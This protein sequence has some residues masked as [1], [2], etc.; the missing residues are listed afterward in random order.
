MRSFALNPAAETA[1]SEVP[2]NPLLEIVLPFSVFRVNC[3]SFPIKVRFSGRIIE[4]SSC[5][6][7]A[8]TRSPGGPPAGVKLLDVV[9]AIKNSHLGVHGTMSLTDLTG[10]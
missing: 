10:A 4:L 6:V 9:F 1:A 2:M 7:H 5:K 3:A 8:K